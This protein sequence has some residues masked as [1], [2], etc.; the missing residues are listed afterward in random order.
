MRK[1]IRIFALLI[2]ALLLLWIAGCS[3]TAE[4]S[5]RAGP[6]ISISEFDAIRGPTETP[7][8]NSVELFWSFTVEDAKILS[9]SFSNQ[10]NAIPP[11]NA[12]LAGIARKLQHGQYRIVVA[13]ASDGEFTVRENTAKLAD[14]SGITL[15]SVA[16]LMTLTKDFG[17]VL[18]THTV[19]VIT[20]FEAIF[21][22]N[23]I[24]TS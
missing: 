21:Q 14:D 24:Q 10:F 12:V 2:T 5:I 6:D 9:A 20:G 22:A 17:V 11:P 3:K 18:K 1:T 7:S 23:R 16:S 13:V 8:Q 15:T 19:N 4:A